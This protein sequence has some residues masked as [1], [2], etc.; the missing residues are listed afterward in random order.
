MANYVLTKTSIPRPITVNQVPAEAL[1]RMVSVADQ[2]ERFNLTQSTVQNGDTVYQIDTKLM[3]RVIDHT[4]L[5]NS[6]GYQVYN[7]AVYWENVREKPVTITENENDYP[8]WNTNR[9]DGG[10]NNVIPS[11]TKNYFIGIEL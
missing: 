11:R 2:A 1:E 10:L 7:G 5:N 6:D 9:T 3:Y 8:E 4:N